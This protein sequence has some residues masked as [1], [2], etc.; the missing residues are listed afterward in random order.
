MNAVHTGSSGHCPAHEGPLFDPPEARSKA[1][2]ALRRHGVAAPPAAARRDFSATTPYVGM[3]Q[4]I[5]LVQDRDR[6]ELVKGEERL[7]FVKPG[8]YTLD[9]MD[10]SS[11]FRIGRRQDLPR[12]SPAPTYGAG[13]L[14]H[15][16]GTNR[17]A[18]P[19]DCGL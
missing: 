11:V 18:T 8:K 17:S 16:L 19:A 7:V 4:P 1:R 5:L 2:D 6:A 14:S 15:Y 12:S 9:V 10:F 3:S 13:D